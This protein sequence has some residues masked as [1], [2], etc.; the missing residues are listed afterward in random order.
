MIIAKPVIPNQYWILKQ[1]D[2]KIGNIEAGGDG[3]SVKINNQVQKFKTI[4][5]V[6]RRIN[7]EFESPPRSV[8]K[9]PKGIYGYEVQGQHFNEVWNAKL[10]VPLF[11]KTAKSKSWFAA[12]WYAVRQGRQW[13]TVHQ[14]KLILLERYDYRGPYHTREQAGDPTST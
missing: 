4:P 6:R 14:P 3:Y 10:N 13:K 5:M 12:G 11:T 9:L 1:D 8:T 2:R 7:I